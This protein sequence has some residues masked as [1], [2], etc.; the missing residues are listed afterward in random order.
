MSTY[1]P[2]TVYERTCT[3]VRVVDGDTLHVAAD[4]GL[5]VSMNLTL[6]LYGID[7]P[8]MSTEAGHV[9]KAFV[10]TW[11]AANGP[12]FSLRT[13]KDRREKYGRYLAD[14]VPQ[15]G[16]PMSLCSALLATGN[17]KVYLP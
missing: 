12:V 14:L 16:G 4:L 17:A 9:S 10:E 11:V 13:V 8:E 3:V 6:R 1:T 2:P 5:D 15:Y 7:A